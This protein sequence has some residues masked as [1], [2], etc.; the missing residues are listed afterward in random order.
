MIRTMTTPGSGLSLLG[1][2]LLFLLPFLPRIQANEAAP[3]YAPNTKRID[4]RYM[5]CISMD[6]MDSM[7]CRLNAT[8]PDICKPNG[9]CYWEDIDGGGSDKPGRAGWYRGLCTRQ[10]WDTPNCLPKTMCD[11]DVRSPPRCHLLS[12]YCKVPTNRSNPTS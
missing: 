9:L 2:V 5:P 4:A 3:C 7:C 6:G 8:D 12:P 10:D 11:D 1:V